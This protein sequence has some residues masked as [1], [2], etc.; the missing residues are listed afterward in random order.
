MGKGVATSYVEDTTAN[1]P[2]CGHKRYGISHDDGTCIDY[3]KED[4]KKLQA[5]IKTM[6]DERSAKV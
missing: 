2:I 6:E 3:L 1:C 4:I 5:R